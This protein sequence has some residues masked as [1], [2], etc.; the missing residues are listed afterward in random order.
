MEVIAIANQK[1]G[2]GKTTTVCNLSAYLAVKGKKV[3][4]IDVDPQGSST[5]HYG[6][7]KWHLENT[8]YDALMGDLSIQ[9]LTMPTMIPNLDIAPTN[10]QLSKAERELA[11]R[12]DRET[13]LKRKL[14]ELD[15]YDYVIIDTPPNLGY[16][17]LNALVA[18]DTILVPVQVEFFALEGLAMLMDMMDIVTD[19]LGHEMKKKYLLT[20]YDA[21]TN[22]SKDIAERIRRRFGGEVFRAVIP[23]NIRLADAP[24]YGQPICLTDPE[25]TGAKAY[26][27][28]AE[29]VIG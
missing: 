13:L 5:T 16:L 15:D 3:L 11:N 7:D 2:C 23:R 26:A 29:E 19:E 25:S 14:D 1:G 8:M 6:I 9:D 10:N 20:M 27:E 12:S 21:R 18:C 22:P 24:S 4:L 28:L 17:T